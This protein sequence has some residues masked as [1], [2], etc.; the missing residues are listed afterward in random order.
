LHNKNTVTL[1]KDL[2]TLC[3]YFLNPRLWLTTELAITRQSTLNTPTP[4]KPKIPRFGEAKLLRLCAY[5][6]DFETTMVLSP[7]LDQL[8]ALFLVLSESR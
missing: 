5:D 6:K 3:L 1:P 8:S 4:K 2:L 7:L